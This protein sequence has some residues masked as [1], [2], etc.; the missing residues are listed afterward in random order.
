MS[1]GLSQ[2]GSQISPLQDQNHPSNNMLRLG[3]AG[4]AKFEHLIPPSNPSPLHTLSSS[5]FFMPDAN[6]GPFPSK[7]LHG[8]MQL[9][10]LQSNTSNSTSA[11]NLF[12]L[13]FFSNNGNISP[14][15]N[16][17][18]ANTSTTTTSLV[19]SGF[20]NP[21]PFNNN[22]HGGHGTTLFSNNMGDHVGSGMSPLYGTSLQH[23]NIT[24]HMSA[25]A[26]LQ[27]AAQ[28]GST[29]S[30][31]NTPL[32]RGMGNSSASG[33]KSDRPPVSANFGSSFESA[34]MEN[35]NQ[36]HGLMNSLANGGSSI[37]G[38]GHGQDN[39]FS[40]FNVSMEQHHNSTNFSN[41][42]EAKFHQSVAAGI[43][44]SDKLTLDFLGVGPGMV[45]NIGAGFSQR[46]Q[47]HSMSINLSPLDPDIKSAQANQQF[48]NAKLQ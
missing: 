41:V 12:N 30:S 36:L 38:G 27:K 40:G 6:Q 20:L 42:N 16:S 25:T 8:L 17:D 39:S 22:G 18:N 24:P 44:G 9:P 7:P 14:V 11:T 48:G 31:N 2:V 47:Q 34:T 35:E 19:N 15:S 10:D 32:L 28:M 21:N 45:R 46:E 29:T 43:G 33:T 23:E 3:S 1:L 26:L 4:A 5:T 13:S 37:F